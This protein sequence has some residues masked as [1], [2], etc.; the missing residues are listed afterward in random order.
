MQV[1]KTKGKT[2]YPFYGIFHVVAIK[3]LSIYSAKD[4]SPKQIMKYFGKYNL[5][6]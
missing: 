4:V 2:Q 6:R 5:Q 3:Q 1:I